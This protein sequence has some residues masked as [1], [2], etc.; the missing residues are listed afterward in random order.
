MKDEKML[1]QDK[2]KF[3]CDAK[4]IAHVSF[5]KG[6]WKNGLITE[7]STDYFMLDERLDGL[8]PVFF[9]EIK[10]ITL[11]TNDKLKEDKDGRKN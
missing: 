7:V 6:F 9:L 2:A 10:D 5:N 1:M 3:F 8:Q 4:K 11:Y